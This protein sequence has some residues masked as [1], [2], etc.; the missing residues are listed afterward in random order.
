MMMREMLMKRT[1]INSC[2]FENQSCQQKN[3]TSFSY[4]FLLLLMRYLIKKRR[5]FLFR[6][7]S[8]FVTAYKIKL[9]YHPLQIKYNNI[10]D[11]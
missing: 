3:I 8:E 9:C 1:S 5:Q 6:S 10:R 11:S 2:C 7:T 4:S